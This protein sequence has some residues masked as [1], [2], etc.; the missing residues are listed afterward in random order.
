MDKLA[1]INFLQI[2]KTLFGKLKKK[3]VKVQTRFKNGLPLA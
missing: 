2:M 3:Q 1:Y